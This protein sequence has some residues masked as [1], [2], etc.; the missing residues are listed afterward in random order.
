MV[1]VDIRRRI[2][3]G[4]GRSVLIAACMALSLIIVLG[5]NPS[6]CW[7]YHIPTFLPT[8]QLLL[9][10]FSSFLQI[11]RVVS[12][13]QIT[14]RARLTSSSTSNGHLDHCV[15]LKSHSQPDR[16]FYCRQ[17]QQLNKKQSSL[18]VFKTVRAIPKLKGSTSALRKR[19][20]FHTGF[21][22][23]FQHFF[24]IHC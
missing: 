6:F 7:V 23:H 14:C 3:R 22:N 8:F 21:V 2:G 5:S 11:F 13:K 15:H 10:E 18:Y 1:L 12:Q 20:R 17:G 16:T 24:Y 9:S 4:W 19:E